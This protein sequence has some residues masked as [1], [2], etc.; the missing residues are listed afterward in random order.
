MGLNILFISFLLG[1]LF[2]SQQIQATQATNLAEAAKLHIETVRLYKEEKF[3]EALVLAKKVIEIREKLL[4]QNDALLATSYT[5][6]GYLY[7][8][9]G[10]YYDAERALKKALNIEESRAGNDHVNQTELLTSIG[11]LLHAQNNPMDAEPFFKRAIAA[12][13]KSYGT[14]HKELAEQLY[15]LA[16]FYEKISKPGKAV[17]LFD[18]M[19]AIRVKVF[20]EASN[21][22][23]E[24]VEYNACALQQDKKVD[25]ADL[26][27]K[28]SNDIET[29][30]HPVIGQVETGVLT[31]SAT[32]KV[33]PAYPE[34]ARATK[35]QGAVI[36]H[37][38]INES[39]IVEEAR[40]LCGSD[41]LAPA[42]EEAARKWEFTT[43]KLNGKPVKVQGRLTF[44]FVLR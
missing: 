32:K 12:T 15:H 36:V 30:L 26:Y 10:K 41:L 8:G 13:E 38:I 16:K 28:R 34:Y 1:L 33:Q 23:K 40:T 19:I 9:L 6:L 18:R 25:Q 44:T 14:D 20:G 7:R 37:V 43:T 4:P 35:V 2:Q 11:W 27:W 29:A 22:T 3:S 42:S 39:G 5:N 17:P 21:E 31:G 24:A